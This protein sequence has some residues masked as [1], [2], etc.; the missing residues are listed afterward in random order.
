MDAFLVFC[1]IFGLFLKLTSAQGPVSPCPQVFRYEN[2]GYRWFGTIEAPNP[3][4]YGSEMTIQIRMAIRARLPSTYVGKIELADERDIVLQKIAQTWPIKYRVTFPLISPLP[5]VMKIT[6][7]GRRLCSGDPIYGRFITAID[8]EHTLHSGASAIKNSPR[9]KLV[10]GGAIPTILPSQTFNDFNSKQNNQI[11]PQNAQYPAID[12]RN[13]FSGDDGIVF[14]GSEPPKAVITQ[15]QY[16][17]ES[18]CGTTMIENPLILHGDFASKGDW[19][20]LVA[21]FLKKPRGLEFICAGSLVSEN[22][23]VTAGHCVKKKNGYKVNPD[24]LVLKIGVHNIQDWTEE[25]SV[26]KS[27]LNIKIHEQYDVGAILNNDI[28]VLTLGTPVTFTDYIRPVCLWTGDSDLELVV[29]KIAS[30]VGW[31]KDEKGAP[32]TPE[33]K[34]AKVPI[35]STTTCKASK[36]EFFKLTS[37]TTLCAGARDESGPCNGDSGGGL[38]VRYGGRWV[39]RGIVSKSLK[40]PE[41]YSCDLKEFVVYT[42]AAKFV[43]FIR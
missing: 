20:W 25:T 17:Q 30:V 39:L 3:P 35:V 14:N 24:D 28:A 9:E 13:T 31:G 41:S 38:Y 5:T 7:A 43:D 42:D 27:V 37:D 19:P 10:I 8:L 34:V 2:D 1:V 4:P 6:F 22:K 23:V 18:I 15:A 33:P 16:Y 21:M 36:V 26:T 29:G 11:G 32:A 40:D 12:V